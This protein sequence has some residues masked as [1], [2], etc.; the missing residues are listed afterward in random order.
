MVAGQALADSTSV[1]LLFETGR[2]PVYYFPRADVRTDLL[3]ASGNTGNDPVKGRTTYFDVLVNGRTIE[4]AAWTCEGISAHGP[5][6]GNLIA[7]DWNKM[8]AWFEED[9]EVFV[10]A[11]DPY[12]RVDV[13]ESSRHIEISVNG[14]KIA[15]SHRPM[16][17]FET[18]LPTRYYLPKLDV[19]LDLLQ[20]SDTHTGCPYKGTADYWSVLADGIEVMDVVWCYE[21]PIPEI[22]K[23]A[24]RLCFYDEKVDVR[25]DGV[26][27]KR[28]STRWS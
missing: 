23:I 19:R 13:V 6:I 27:Q 8:D 3:K 17:L 14:T 7:F 2:L 9:E 18:G 5:A 25:I 4:N 10:H 1:E 16:M 22:P 12:H 24:G 20:K 28:P 26:L 15:D 11:R 21:T